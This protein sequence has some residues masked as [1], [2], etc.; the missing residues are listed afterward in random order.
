MDAHRALLRSRHCSRVISDAQAIAV[1]V[2]MSREVLVGRWLA[3]GLASGLQRQHL[4]AAR[5]QVAIDHHPDRGGNGTVM[6]RI[7][8]AID[9]AITELGELA[10][11]DDKARKVA[12]NV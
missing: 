10:D 9:A 3:G 6:T 12:T 1:G 4:E 11:A 8:D 5:R 7:N 2:P